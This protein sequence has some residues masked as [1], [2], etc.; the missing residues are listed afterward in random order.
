MQVRAF[1]W[2][3]ASYKH[4]TLKLAS[5]LAVDSPIFS[6]FQYIVCNIEKLGMGPGNKASLKQSEVADASS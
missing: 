4:W 2:I 3:R 6:T 1:A 5:S